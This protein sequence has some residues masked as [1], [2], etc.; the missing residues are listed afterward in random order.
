[1]KPLWF[2]VF[3]GLFSVDLKLQFFE[4]LEHL[5]IDLKD[6]NPSVSGD[7]EPVWPAALNPSGI[8]AY[9]A[10]YGIRAHKN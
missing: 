1:M 6:W 3:I 7:K 10:R 2:V 4:L 5:R 8:R 9:R